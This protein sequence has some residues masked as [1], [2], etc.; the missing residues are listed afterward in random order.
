MMKGDNWQED[1]ER[2]CETA[3]GTDFIVTAKDA[4]S[5]Y[6]EIRSA[7]ISLK[8]FS[9]TNPGYDFPDWRVDVLNKMKDFQI[10]RIL[11]C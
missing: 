4:M 5:R 9:F 1:V 7:L 2:N 3:F 10:R 8:T 6:P 11:S